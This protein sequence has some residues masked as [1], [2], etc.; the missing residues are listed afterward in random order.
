[1]LITVIPSRVFMHSLSRLKL[2]QAKKFMLCLIAATMIHI[3]FFI[4][5]MVTLY[6]VHAVLLNCLESTWPS[7]NDVAQSFW[8]FLSAKY[9]EVLE[10]SDICKKYLGKPGELIAILFSLTAIAGSAI[11]YWVLMSNFLYNSG[12]YI[13]GEFLGFVQFFEPGLRRSLE[14]PRLTYMYGVHVT[15]WLLTL[16]GLKAEVTR[17]M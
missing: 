12:V 4:K 14:N 15:S 16:F 7:N 6:C 11:V 3:N 1:M 8:S 9:D 13:Q 17:Y 5:A 2:E 10:F